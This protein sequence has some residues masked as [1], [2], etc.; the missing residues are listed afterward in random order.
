[1]R[2]LGNVI[3]LDHQL[4]YHSK[5]YIE[6]FRDSGEDKVGKDKLERNSQERSTNILGFTWQEAGAAAIDSQE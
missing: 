5:N 2:L 1:M 6:R 4:V 3:W